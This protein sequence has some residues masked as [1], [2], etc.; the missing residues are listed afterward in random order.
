M[1]QP[2]KPARFFREGDKIAFG[3]TTLEVIHVPGHSPGGVALYNEDEKMLIAGDILFYGSIGRTDLPGGEHELLI[4]GIKEKLLV[5]DPSTQVFP[6]HGPETTI[7]D[8]I[9]NNPFL[10]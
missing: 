6:G 1:H 3:N 10:Q 2:P 9:K 7:G 5:L 8:E 4:N